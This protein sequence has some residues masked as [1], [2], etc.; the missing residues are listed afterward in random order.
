MSHSMKRIYAIF[1][2]DVKDLTK[3]MY[4]LTTLI[5]PIVMAVLL[6]TSG[7]AQLGLYF[8]LINLTF[9]TVG[10]YV[11]S[12]LIA[13]EK[14]KNTLRGL[15]M[16]PATM[17]EIL[18]GKSIVSILLTVLTFGICHVIMDG[19]WANPAVLLPALIITLLFCIVIGTVLGLLTRSLMEAS[20]IIVPFI[21]LFGMGPI[22]NVF[23][24]EYAVL[25]VLEY[26]PNF[27]LEYL[28]RDLDAGNKMAGVAGHYAILAAWMAAAI[29]TMVIV[30]Q[31]R[32]WDE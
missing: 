27:Q 26:L 15:M 20:V 10:T 21:F 30:F 6:T 31:K 5:M 18:I 9:V 23:I 17:A 32:T 4:V 29:V 28:G 14:E 13:E 11:Q 24:E 12:A 3:N 25:Q 16:S 2:K 1:E 7:P 22:F 19:E 8:M